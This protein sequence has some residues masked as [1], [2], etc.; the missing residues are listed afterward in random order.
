MRSIEW[1]RDRVDNVV[2]GQSIDHHD[3]SG[4]AVGQKPH[5]GEEH[6]TDEGPFHALPDEVGD[7]LGQDG[8]QTAHEILHQAVHLYANSGP[9]EVVTLRDPRLFGFMHKSTA[10]S[11]VTR[12]M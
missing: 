9:H 8:N 1:R 11:S 4:Q 6:H 7:F 3:Q 12:L 2:R 10:L 5:A